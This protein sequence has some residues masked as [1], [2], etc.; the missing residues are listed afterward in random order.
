M[1]NDV[2]WSLDHPDTVLSV[3]GISG[4]SLLGFA[5]GGLFGALLGAGAAS[6][7]MLF[8]SQVEPRP[9]EHGP[10]Q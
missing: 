10:Q 4:G 3:A 7:I 9:P 1:S 5:S 6:A 2:H 8:L